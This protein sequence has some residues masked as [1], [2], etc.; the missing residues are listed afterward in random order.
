M[1]FPTTSLVASILVLFACFHVGTQRRLPDTVE[2]N[3]NSTELNFGNGTRNAGLCGHHNNFCGE[4][5]GRGQGGGGLLGGGSG[6]GGGKDNNSL[7]I[8]WLLVV[9]TKLSTIKIILAT[10]LVMVLLIKKFLMAAA[11]LAPVILNKIK[12]ALVHHE[13]KHVH[14]KDD[15]DYDR[16]FGH[17]QRN[18]VTQQQQQNMQFQNTYNPQ[19]Y[20]Q[21]QQYA[22]DRQR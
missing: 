2:D 5:T 6:G 12:M 10:T 17:V 20:Q 4:Q 13:P 22:A 18:Y 3:P 7:G 15:E 8:I 21:Y 19:Q 11:I 16:I 14:I 9:L 1:C